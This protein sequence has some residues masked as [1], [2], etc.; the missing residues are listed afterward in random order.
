MLLGAKGSFSLEADL[1]LLMVDPDR[2]SRDRF[3]H[4]FSPVLN[5]G[6][7]T[8]ASTADEGMKHLNDEVFFDCV[9][10]A[11]NL[12]V[13]EVADFHSAAQCTA[14]GCQSSY[15][16][17]LKARE[18]KPDFIARCQ[19]GGI[20]GFVCEPYS[21]DKLLTLTHTIVSWRNEKKDPDHAAAAKLL[22]S[23]AIHHVDRAA[24]LLTLGKSANGTAQR[25]KER[26]ELLSK[27]YDSDQ[28]AFVE[29][30][31]HSFAKVSAPEYEPEKVRASAQQVEIEVPN[32]E[33]KERVTRPDFIVRKRRPANS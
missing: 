3:R 10:I 26:H 13:E 7:V 19:L 1:R 22:F 8:L 12:G 2:G 15:V 29:S 16:L 30:L 24:M 20:Q 23:D 31:L 17:V 21:P 5:G 11:S 25:L 6:R 9:F 18:Q 14:I 4:A 28:E 27:I 33:K 32:G